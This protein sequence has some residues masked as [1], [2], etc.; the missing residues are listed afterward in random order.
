MGMLADLGSGLPTRGPA[1]VSTRDTKQP[2]GAVVMVPV[3][4]IE[5]SGE[6]AAA[7]IAPV[8]ERQPVGSCSA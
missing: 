8:D 7:E 6:T 3:E 1:A 5:P 4:V 2:R